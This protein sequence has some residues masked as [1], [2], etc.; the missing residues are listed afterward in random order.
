MLPSHFSHTY[1]NIILP[2]MRG[3]SKGS[4]F[5]MFPHQNPV[6]TSSFPYVLHALP[7]L[8]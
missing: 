8:I 3:S 7:I 6:W 1:F 4:P 2:Y 5:L